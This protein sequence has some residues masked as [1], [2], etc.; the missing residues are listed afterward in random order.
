MRPPCEPRLVQH[1]EGKNWIFLVLAAARIFCDCKW[2][3]AG[4]FSW[5]PGWLGVRRGLEAL[6]FG[7]GVSP[8]DVG[9]GPPVSQGP[10]VKRR[11]RK[12]PRRVLSILIFYGL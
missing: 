6:R 11:D 9:R 7:I 4:D 1:S 5:G 2:E 3:L 10:V 8:E 12:V